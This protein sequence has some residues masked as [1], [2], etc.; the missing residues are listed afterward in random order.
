MPVA[1]E[2]AWG[3]TSLNSPGSISNNG[4]ANETFSNVNVLPGLHSNT[5]SMRCGA[6]A[7]PTSANRAMASATFYGA[8]DLHVLNEVLGFD[9]TLD[10]D[11][12]GDGVLSITGKH[13]NTTWLGPSNKARTNFNANPISRNKTVIT[14][15]RTPE[16]SGRGVKTLIVL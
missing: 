14:D 2:Y 16:S 13:T 7:T 9:F 3:N 11:D 15:I 8:M 6:S 12:Y 1:G 4:Q 5:N 10:E